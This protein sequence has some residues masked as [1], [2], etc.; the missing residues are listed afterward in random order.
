MSG[1]VEIAFY[2]V[3]DK[4]VASV[5][6]CYELF[7]DFKDILDAVARLKEKKTLLN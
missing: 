6:Y 1:I 7:E 3:G 4:E 2:R 5:A